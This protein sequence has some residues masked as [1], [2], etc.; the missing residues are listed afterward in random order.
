LTAACIFVTITFVGGHARLVVDGGCHG[1]GLR[2]E[3]GKLDAFPSPEV[4]GR[5]E[6]GL[7]RR[8]EA[9]AV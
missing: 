5:G 3:P 6:N 9:V 8:P 1:A 4:V 7:E 2:R